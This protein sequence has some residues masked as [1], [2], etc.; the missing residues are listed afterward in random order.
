[1]LIGDVAARLRGALGRNLRI[2]DLGCAQGFFALNLAAEGDSVVGVDHLQSNIDLCRALAAER[3]GADATFWH[4]RIEDVV[5]RLQSDEYDLVFCLGASHHLEH[6]LGIEAIA[7]LVGHIA[8]C[9]DVGIHELPASEQASCYVGSQPQRSAELLAPYAFVRQLAEHS[10]HPPSIDRPLYFASCKYWMIGEDFRA[11]SSMKLE[12]HGD[13]LGSYRGTRRC[14]FSD[15]AMLKKMSLDLPELRAANQA[16]YDNELA[17]LCSPARLPG[18]PRLIAHARESSELWLLRE[19]LPGVLLSEMMERG[20]A[21]VP[22][23]LLDPLVEQLATLEAAGLYHANIRCWNLLVSPRGEVGFIDYGSISSISEDCLWPTDLLLAFLITAREI[24]AGRLASSAE[25]RAP[26]LDAMQLPSRYRDAFFRVFSLPQE[27]WTFR[28]LRSALLAASDAFDIPSWALI[29]ARCEAALLQY[30]QNAQVFKADTRH[31]EQISSAWIEVASQSSGRAE[32]RERQRQQMQLR[33]SVSMENASHWTLGATD[34]EDRLQRLSAKHGLLVC[35]IRTKQRDIV[36][37]EDELLSLRAKLDESLSNAHSWFVRASERD[38]QLKKLVASR[39]WRLTRPLRFGVR[40]VQSPRQTARRIL[41]AVMHRA[42]A[43]PR[44]MRA[45]KPLLRGLPAF[46]GR[47]RM[48]AIQ[49]GIVAASVDPLVVESGLLH[50]GPGVLA[51]DV[52][53][54]SA[55]GRAIHASLLAAQAETEAQQCAS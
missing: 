41:L 49:N 7:E 50:R 14:Y 35:E 9:I 3:A 32:E 13:E 33:S 52:E 47:L 46:R 29:P 15:G 20:V 42:V 23:S 28:S 17:Y 5:R 12:S 24:V 55:R 36:A 2:L 6:E 16:E 31:A 39:S 8:R 26:L 38:A 1:M 10:T 34:E 18:T 21:Y 40:A 51:V 53:Q 44:L 37:L 19:R 54:L 22:E 4:E 27:Q 45:I 30:A 25:L 11:F 48:M 43:R